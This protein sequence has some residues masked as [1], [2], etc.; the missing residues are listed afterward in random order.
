MA[1]SDVSKV[2]D[3]PTPASP[4]RGGITG[5]SDWQLR[6]GFA[7]GL[8][9]CGG[10]RGGPSGHFSIS[11]FPSELAP[12]SKRISSH[13]GKVTDTAVVLPGCQLC[14]QQER[15]RVYCPEVLA[16]FLL[17]LYN[18]DWV[19][20]PSLNPSLWSRANG[21]PMSSDAGQRGAKV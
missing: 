19:R 7:S 21:A 14:R 9:G 8:A 17:R 18:S 5:F 16:K 3:N 10:S 12:F 4:V 15:A 2:N 6:V 1:E 13:R 11:L 20:C